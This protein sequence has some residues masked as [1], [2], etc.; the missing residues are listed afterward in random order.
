M[1]S[2]FVEMESS[3][4]VVCKG[5]ELVRKYLTDTKSKAQLISSFVIWR[6]FVIKAK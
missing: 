1:M 5:L 3:V 4:M 2:S 6:N